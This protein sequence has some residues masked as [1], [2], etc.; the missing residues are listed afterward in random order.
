[1]KTKKIITDKTCYGGVMVDK[2]YLHFDDGTVMQVNYGVWGQ[3]EVG[4]EYQFDMVPS[5]KAL[6]EGP[7]IDW[8]EAHDLQQKLV[9]SYV[10]ENEKLKDEIKLLENSVKSVKNSFEYFQD[11]FY[12]QRDLIEKFKK[13]SMGAEEKLKP[14]EKVEKICDEIE[15]IY[16]ERDFYKMHSQILE[17]AN[18]ELDRTNKLMKDALINMWECFEIRS[19]IYHNDW[20]GLQALGNKARIC[21]EEIGYEWRNDKK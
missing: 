16:R 19:E 21:L 5:D 14:S 9:I 17:T 4:D 13:R 10:L 18:D 7:S 20:A 11:R 6:N 15:E 8:K 3:F 12:K 2:Y 1:M